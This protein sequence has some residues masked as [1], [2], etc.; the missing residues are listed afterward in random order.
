MKTRL[1]TVC[2]CLCAA[3]A[4]HA[5]APAVATVDLEELIRLHPN[6]VSDKKLLEETL[7]EY[8]GEGDDLQRKLEGL[9]DEFEKVRKEAQDPALSDKARKTAEENAA[10]AHEALVLADRKA[11]ETMQL[12]QQQLSEQEMRMLKRTTAEIREAVEKC[13]AERKLTLVLAANQVVYADKA[14]DITDVVMQRL[15]I[16]RPAKDADKSAVEPMPAPSSLA[17]VPR[18]ADKPAV[19]VAAP[20]PA[21]AN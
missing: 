15:N 20:A 6:T 4:V 13:A 16:R 12:R 21:P 10:R 18:T 14:L 8:K 7:K 9:Q 1:L 19:P 5:Q 3:A 2:L 17:P 11:R